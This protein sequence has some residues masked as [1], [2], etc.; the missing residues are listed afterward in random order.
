MPRLKQTRVKKAR[1]SQHMSHKV[2]LYE[3]MIR[4]VFL[5]LVMSY[6]VMNDTYLVLIS[7]E[8]GW[9]CFL[10]NSPVRSY[11]HIDRRICDM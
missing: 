2:L 3:T 6:G 8:S 1:D 4:L 5:N 11:T 7:P 10:K 9:S